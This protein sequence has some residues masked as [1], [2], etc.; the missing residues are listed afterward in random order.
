M[1]KANAEMRREQEA[2]PIRRWNAAD[3]TP[4]RIEILKDLWNKGFSGTQIACEL[5]NVS[6]NAVIGKVHRLGLGGRK[7]PSR[8]RSK[9]QV[10]QLAAARGAV[11]RTSK[12][13]PKPKPRQMPPRPSNTIPLEDLNDSV[14]RWPIGDGPPYA[15]CGC[16]VK[17]GS[18]YCPE[19]AKIAKGKH[20]G[21]GEPVRPSYAQTAFGPRQVAL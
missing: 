20:S 1:A 3:W 7:T 14:C 8:P 12:P 9:K 15:F 5:G 11:K 19:H 13:K 21:W 2:E 17:P 4:E 6:R 16:K 10:A 18:S